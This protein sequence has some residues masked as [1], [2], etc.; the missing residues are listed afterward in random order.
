MPKLVLTV[1]ALAVFSVLAALVVVQPARSQP[2]PPGGP[3]VLPT[4]SVPTIPIQPPC[5]P[6]GCAGTPTPAP[7]ST[8]LPTSTPIPPTLIPLQLP[9][10]LTL[11]HTG[12]SPGARQ[13]VTV[14]TNHGLSVTVAIV[15]PNGDRLTHSG[16]ANAKG[17]LAWT[18]TQ[19]GSEITHASRNAQVHATVRSGSKSRSASKSYTIAF[20]RVDVSVEPRTQSR[21]HSVGVWV[22]GPAFMRLGA[23]IA[24]KGRSSTF[25]GKSGSA[26]WVLFSYQIP[27]NAPAGRGTARGYS[28]AAHYSGQATTTFSVR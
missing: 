25:K 18:F 3:P 4:G 28:L 5:P 23:Q 2:A 26:G 8:P 16:K 24:L 12:V 17:K 14:T 6:T 1:A 20:G 10:R 13:T 27:S 15:F 7:T 21:G 9:L 11:A 19:A 22:H